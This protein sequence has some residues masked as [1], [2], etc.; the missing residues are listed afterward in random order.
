MS[1]FELFAI[2]LT[3]FE[4][5]VT[6]C[7]TVRL[8]CSCCVMDGCHC[9]VFVGMVCLC[10]HGSWF[11]VVCHGCLSWFVMH[12]HKSVVV[13]H[14]DV[15]FLAPMGFTHDLEIEAVHKAF[16]IVSHQFSTYKTTLCSNIQLAASSWPLRSCVLYTA[17]HTCSVYMC[18]A[19]L[20]LVVPC[21]YDNRLSSGVGNKHEHVTTRATNQY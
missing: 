1:R 5:L 19:S 11:V 18:L 4:R 7:V 2:V 3:W 13:E 8:Y 9:V 14:A 16:E 15:M 20:A 12:C 6:G 21:L 10:F 17:S